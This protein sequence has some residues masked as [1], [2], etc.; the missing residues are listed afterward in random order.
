MQEL[1]EQIVDY[2]KGIWLK[3]RYIIIMTW[4]ICPLGW[5]YVSQLDDVYESNARVFADTQSILGPLLKGLTV[6]TNPEMQIQLM[7]KTLLSRPNLE[8]ISR[9]T[10]LD[11]QAITPQ[12][13]EALI[14]HLRN[15]IVIEKTGGKNENIFSISFENKNPEVARNV[16]Q[17]ALTVFIENTLGDNRN[18]ADSAQKFLDNQLKEYENRL[19]GSEAR[20]T[21]F[22]QK[23]RDVLPSE[24]GGYYNQLRAEKDKLA[25]A[26]LALQEIENSIKSASSQLETSSN[27]AQKSSD[28]INDASSVSTSYDE[29]IK[30]IESNLDGLLLRYTDRHPDVA[31][32]KRLLENLNT[33]RK[34]ELD[35]YYETIKQND[36][37]NPSNLNALNINPVYQEIHIKLNELQNQGAS[38]RV[39]VNNY[40]AKVND[41]ETK[42]H[43]I[44]EIE[45][46][47]I[48]LDRGYN[49]T[50]GK[51][52]ELLRR[53]ETAQLAQQ[54][55]KT[56]S[57]INFKI[58]DPPRAPSKPTGPKRILLLILVTLL[59]LSAGA[60]LS[61][62]FSQLNP[63]VTSVNQI[64]NSLG[65]PVF[66]IISATDNLGLKQ[67]HKRKAL[68]FIASNVALFILLVSFILY[69]L[70]PEAIKEP[71]K[72]IF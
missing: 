39:R 35:N 52:E 5:Y 70:Y 4:L 42:V 68:I 49:I 13:Y 59:G 1:I 65:I 12:G 7:V 3:R 23:Y 47:L 41:L 30:Q 57:N 29:R 8:R 11:V 10:D 63:V 38:L 64:Q 60:G 50:K 66:G 56:T 2:S 31:E 15:E 45:A 36:N 54:A 62:L 26:Q 16:V 44:P 25:E 72:R 71:L 32:T 19:L 28:K 33:L 9:M 58:I 37:G 27:S 17:S 61:F 55:D 46:E 18:D 69:V 48:A 24:A 51:Y 43:I 14:S 22:K 40:Q 67:W 34:E 21:D 53:K 20:L 6:E